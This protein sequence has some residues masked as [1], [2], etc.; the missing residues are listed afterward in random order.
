MKNPNWTQDELI[1][2]LDLYFRVSPLNTTENHPEIVAVSDL[3]NR[4]PIHTSRPDAERFR[5]P[6]GVYMKL[7][8]FL[9]LDP[10]YAGTGLKAGSHKDEEVWNEFANDRAR[11]QKVAQAIL[12]MVE[13]D[14][15]ESQTLRLF[16][17][18]D[19][20]EAPEGKVLTLLHRIRERNRELVERKKRTVLA[21]TGHL[22]CEACT[23]DFSA[24]Y[25]E[26]GAGFIEC[27]H[28]TPISELQPG[29]K[30]R[31]N[32]LALVCANCH[33]MLHRGKRWLS[34]EELLTLL[35]PIRTPRP[36]THGNTL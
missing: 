21:Q 3:L 15:E 9:R 33:R 11:L 5:N 17:D 25:G 31:I 1:L 4:L 23:F 26:L 2:A 24:V 20:L 32:D 36:L 28:R 27:H 30:T 13:T 29:Q 6:N 18:D 19:L 10:S 35:R 14:D 16:S 7:C 12:N 34:V 22:E 8:N